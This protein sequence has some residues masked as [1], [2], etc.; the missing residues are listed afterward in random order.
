MPSNYSSMLYQA[1]VK[2]KQTG[3]TVHTHPRSFYIGSKLNLTSLIPFGYR[4]MVVL[5][6]GYTWCGLIVQVERMCG[7]CLVELDLIPF[8]S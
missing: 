7:A 3:S 4:A 5:E 6:I 2:S 1:Q 8:D